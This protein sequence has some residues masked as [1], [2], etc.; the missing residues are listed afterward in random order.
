MLEAVVFTLQILHASDLEGGV[1][2]IEDAP[3][4]AAIVDV[5]E[6]QFTNTVIL[7]AGDNYLPG[8]FLSAAGDRET[9]RDGGLFNDAYNALFGL[10]SAH[11]MD[12]YAGLREGAGRLDISVMNIIGFDASAVGNH[13]LDLGS[14]AF[15]HIIEADFRGAGLGDDRWVGAQ[16]PY[17]SANLDFS[18]DAA[19]ANLF[20]PEVLTTAAFLTGPAQSLAGGRTGPKLARASI[21]EEGGEQIG[22]VGATTPL[23]ESISSPSGTTVEG[24][25]TNDMDALA[26]RLQPVIDTLEAMHVNKIIVV[27]HLQR[28]D[29]EKALIGK[30]SGV[31]VII[32]GGSDTLLADSDDLLHPGD[33]AAGDYPFE[34]INADGDPAV[35]VSTDGEYSYVGRL[36]I[37]FDARGKLVPASLD[38]AV[39]GVFATADATLAALY[40]GTD[41][42]AAGSKAFLVKELTDAVTGVV[43]A[44]DGAIFGASAVFLEGRR[45]RVRTEET[46]LGNLTADANLAAARGFDASVSVSLKN[47]GGIRAPIGEVAGDGRLKPPQ[48]NPAAGK[49]EGQI[50]Q[51]DIENALRFNNGL[52]LLTLTA[53]GLEQ[54]LEHSVAQ[55]APG[56]TPGRFP[57]V[58]GLSFSFDPNATAI[59]FDA[60]GNVVTDGARIR[61]AAI[62]DDRGGVKDVLV[63]AGAV[64]GDPNRPIR[65]VTV[66]FLAGGGDGFRLDVL[67]D[68][69]VDLKDQG[70]AD[71]DAT[72]AAAG[73]E[74]DA[75]AEYLEDNFS[76]TPLIEPETGAVE[77]TRIQNLSKRSDSVLG[78][79]LSQPIAMGARV[80][81]FRS[82]SVARLA[83]APR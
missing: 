49:T 78:G 63:E 30:L 47:G 56:V 37:G 59:A 42:Y 83:T 54:I 4:F 74:Q 12:A 80:N 22:V 27:S 76:A 36:V 75:L 39:S 14:G 25:K 65:I 72:F 13:E 33:V 68:D 18:G 8:P 81:V 62:L 5:L 6:D 73:S 61:S 7:S 55:V 71:G 9:F 52:T 64:V 48:A 58:A 10:P 50:S 51:L 57:Q 29:L 38:E 16:F 79:A 2:A 43:T 69:R 28:I 46:N 23:L 24:A 26:A 44:K 77:D 20:T 53:A 1:H 66:D 41:P 34:T 67:A 11:T 19:L 15:A 31:D 82:S 70:L 60:A 35:I 3:K 17:L 45:E 32:A 21:V 40:G